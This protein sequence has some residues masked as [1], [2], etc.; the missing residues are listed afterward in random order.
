MNGGEILL[1]MS[2]RAFWP[3][4]IKGF[5]FGAFVGAIA[6]PLIQRSQMRRIQKTQLDSK[7]SID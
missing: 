1:G 6:G 7:A 3:E 4:T 5:L 2:D